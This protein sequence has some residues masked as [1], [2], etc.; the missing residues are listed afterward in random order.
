M[1]VGD[2]RAVFRRSRK[3]EH[4]TSRDDCRRD[5][6]GSTTSSI[7]HRRPD[8]KVHSGTQ[9]TVHRFNVGDSAWIRAGAGGVHGDGAGGADGMRGDGVGVGDVGEVHGGARGSGHSAGGDDGRGAGR[10][11]EQAW[12]VDVA[13]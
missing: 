2:I 3:P 4:T 1:A 7:L 13:A 9:Q 11:R 8:T 12:S 10:Q 5:K 6:L